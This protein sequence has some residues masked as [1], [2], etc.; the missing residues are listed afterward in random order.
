M[1]HMPRMLEASRRK[2][3]QVVCYSKPTRPVRADSG[4][5]RAVQTVLQGICARM[6]LP[7]SLNRPPAACWM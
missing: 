6:K 1:L 7:E 3:S 2:R 5:F 4:Q